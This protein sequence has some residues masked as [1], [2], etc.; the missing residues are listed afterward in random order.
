VCGIARNLTDA[1]IVC[2]IRLE[3][4]EARLSITDK[5][6]GTSARF[7]VLAYNTEKSHI[8]RIMYFPDPLC[9]LYGNA[10][11]PTNANNNLLQQLDFSS[12]ASER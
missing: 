6:I 5:N 3:S 9:H 10:T 7:S 12:A 2:M 8:K 1:H 11:G 4:I